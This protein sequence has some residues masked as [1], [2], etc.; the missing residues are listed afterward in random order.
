MNRRRTVQRDLVLATVQKSCTHPT[1]DEIF[2]SVV[3]EHPSISKATVYRNLN[4]LVEAGLVRRVPLPG[5]LPDHFDRT[6]D[7]HYHVYCECC[8]RVSD[9]DLPYQ[10]D[11]AERIAESDG[12]EVY[13]HEIVFHGICPDCKKKSMWEESRKGEERNGFERNED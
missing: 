12:F 4:L 8:G 1:A 13:Q 10:A 6:L 3:A 11:L 2:A 9:V 5:T 7:E